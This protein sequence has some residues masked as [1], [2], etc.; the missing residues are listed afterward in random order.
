LS[1][2]GHGAAVA[3]G[4]AG[5]VAV[6]RTPDKR[7]AIAGGAERDGPL[8]AAFDAV[9]HLADAKL[10]LACWKATS[11]A[12]E[13]TDARGR[14]AIRGGFWV[15]CPHN[16]P[17]W[18]GSGVFWR[19]VGAG[20]P[21][22]G[23]RRPF[24]LPDRRNDIRHPALAPPDHR[25]GRAL[26]PHHAS[27]V[28]PAAAIGGSIRALGTPRCGGSA[29]PPPDWGQRAQLCGR[30]AAGQPAARQRPRLGALVSGQVRR[31]GPSRRRPL[32]APTCRRRAPT[33]GRELTPNR[34]LRHTR[35]R[36]GSAA[37]RSL[38]RRAERPPLS[39]QRAKRS[40][41]SGPGAVAPSRC[42]P[43]QGAILC[44]LP[45]MAE[46]VERV[47]LRGPAI[48]VPWGRCG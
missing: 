11:I 13:Q 8:D 23:T 14:A 1:V 24:R 15:L 38:A 20:T 21:G 28:G 16:P 17:H 40:S 31:R 48:P 6:R 36:Y 42:R 27:E 7:E 26:D 9:A 37:G 30:A 29:E 34:G 19:V 45:A 2:P 43:D 39:G 33:D 25:A 22:R 18:R 32:H 47:G 35:H 4:G 3:L 5:G 10:R 44:R 12:T 41:A 46:R